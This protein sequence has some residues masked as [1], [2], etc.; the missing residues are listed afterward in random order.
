M[1]AAI[2]VLTL[3]AVVALR[4]R[5]KQRRLPPLADAGL[6]ATVRAL[7]SAHAPWFL[8]EQARRRPRGSRVFRLRMP[9]LQHWFEVADPD[10]VRLVFNASL[11]KPGLYADFDGQAC[12]IPTMFTMK[13]SDPR[14]A[15]ARKGVAHAFS[16][17]RIQRALLRGY[18]KLERVLQGLEEL[19]GRPFD[20][21][22]LLNE[23]LLE[24]LG[25]SM[26]GGFDFGLAASAASCSASAGLEHAAP[27][28]LGREFISNLERSLPEYA[29]RQPNDPAR[30]HLL[31][32]LPAALASRCFPLAAAADHAA[33]RNMQIA[34]LVLDRFRQRRDEASPEERAAMDET[35]LG[36]LVNNNAYAS[37]RMRCADVQIFLVAG[38]DTTGYTLAWLLCELARC[39][40]RAAR[41]RDDLA[42]SQPAEAAPYLGA[43]VH[44]TLR[45]WPVAAMGS[46][47]ET[48]EPI[49]LA[50]G[51]R[52]PSG[53]ICQLPF[54]LLHRLAD[55][56]APDE[57]RPERWLD[58]EGKLRTPEG[59]LPVAF[60][61]GPRNCVGQALAMAELKRVTAALA[62][63]F[64][65]EAV[66]P[67]TPDFFLTLKPSGARLRARRWSADEMART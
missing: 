11:D 22:V 56:P 9:L 37:E 62:S 14:F 34:Q 25:A 17:A 38:H 35:I 63:R 15:H 44:E 20:P 66:E 28:A 3:L 19:Q 42:R 67:P 39:P 5:G 55:I 16:S 64:V 47:R 54:L 30:K 4:W 41:L 58:G 45:L 29:L 50:D 2:F 46:A 8:L 60:S 31:R 51:T 61:L 26:L 48:L 24:M 33:R 40:E 59:L 49:E 6:L 10:A 1:I 7:T 53:S 27:P 36:H 57:W 23:L 32:L 12:G 13:S 52:I 18:G 43:C 65:F 21:A